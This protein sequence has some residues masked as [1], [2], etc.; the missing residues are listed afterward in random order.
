MIVRVVV[1]G[2]VRNWIRG[3]S[4]VEVFLEVLLGAGGVAPVAA[5]VDVGAN[6]DFGAEELAIM[7][8]RIVGV[9]D[10]DR[11]RRVAEVSAGWEAVHAET[12]YVLTGPSGVGEIRGG[13]AVRAGAG[14]GG[15]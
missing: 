3:G 15:K 10:F 11:N 7:V 2:V 5:L 1:A 9:E 14:N 12:G 13:V 6:Q 4:E 8:V